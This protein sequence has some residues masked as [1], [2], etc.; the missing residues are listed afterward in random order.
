MEY[1][2]G[3][4]YGSLSCR[5]LLVQTQTGE[6]VAEAVFAYPH[7]VIDR[8]L[9]DGTPLADKWCL[10]HPDDYLDALTHIVPQLLSSSGVARE[11]VVGIGI[12]FAASAVI[13]V[14]E[15]LVPM[16]KS[17]PERPHAWPKMWKHHAADRQ[18]DELTSMCENTEFLERYGGKISSECLLSKVVQVFEEDRFLFDRCDA[19]MEAEDY[20]NSLLCG[21][22]VFCGSAAV[23]KGFWTKDVG[24]PGPDLFTKLHPDL[25]HLPQEKLAEHYP[26][27]R[28]AFPYEKAGELCLEMAEKLGLC[29][30]IAVAG[31]QMDA[32][33]GVSGVGI[34]KPGQLLMVVG[35][36]TAVLVLHDEKRFVEGTTGCIP[37]ANYPGLWTYACGQASVGDAF[38]WFVDNCVPESY[39]IAARER[40]MSVHAYLTELASKLQPG[41][42]GLIALDW[43]GGNRSCLGDPNLSGMILGLT[44][45]TRPEEI[46]RAL[47]EATAFGM[48]AILEAF[49]SSG[50]EIDEITLCGGIPNKNP[51]LV[52]IY[53]DVFGKPLRVSRSTQAPALGSAIYAAAAAG[54]GSLTEMIQRMS[55]QEVKLYTP[56]PANAQ[57]YQELYQAYMRLHDHFGRGV[58]PVMHQ[59]RRYKAQTDMV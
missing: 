42:S 16:S 47:I 35:T 5:G 21:E 56:D 34:T 29:P 48:R 25:A 30:G 27:G 36:S 54:C 45:Q 37:G 20:I 46:Y 11:Q 2:I 12:D 4:D 52:Q 14:D 31:A 38:G 57:R 23:A 39:N 41:E 33:A 18:A 59:L 17:Y 51:M 1:T 40:N 7:G 8:K 9:P 19:F 10:Q 28:I 49:H 44:L 13:P 53:A 26:N 6:I 43:L 58:D 50:V 3:L 24:Y 32:Y 22:P 15:S 55:D